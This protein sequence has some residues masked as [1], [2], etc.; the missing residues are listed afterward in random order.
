VNQYGVETGDFSVSRNG[1]ENRGTSLYPADL[2]VDDYKW[3]WATWTVLWSGSEDAGQLAIKQFDRIRYP[4]NPALDTY[5]MANTWGSSHGKEAAKEQNVLKEID[6]QAE[7]GIDVQQIDDGWQDKNWKP[8]LEWYPTG[9]GN[10]VQR[11]KEKNIRLGLWGAAMPITLEALK[12][13]YD[14]AKFTTYKLDFADLSTHDKIDKTISKIREFILYTHHKV[15][16]NWDVTE[17]AARYG[18]F[19]AREYG[20]VFLE[21]RKADVPTNVVYVPYLV[22]RDLWHLSKYTNL[23]KFQGSVQNKDMVDKKYSD[24]YLHSHSYCSTIPLMSS[25]LFF[26]ETQFLSKE[27]VN[28][29]KPI[30]ATYK[31]VRNEIIDSYVY[32]IGDEPNNETWAGFQA[33]KQ[34]SKVGYVNLFREINN[35]EPEKYVSLKFLA[36]KN[37]IFT[38]LMTNTVFKAKADVN[39]NVKFKMEKPGSCKMYKYVIE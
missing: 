34:G 35:Q 38:D 28:E 15:R 26:Q 33:Y 14:N 17:N 31:K 4:I 19:W 12:Y 3:F 9:W 37:I 23:N 36:G 2:S 6:C 29:I 32:P 7:L 10:V 27:A 18:Y 8:S 30:L 21:N 1:I 16:V 20:S 25:P 39:G 13:N 22:L 5:I 11:A 24:A